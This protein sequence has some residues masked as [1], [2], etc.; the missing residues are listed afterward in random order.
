[1]DT[2]E[3]PFD[4]ATVESQVQPDGSVLP[5]A[6]QQ[7]PFAAPTG[8]ATPAPPE[9]YAHL[10][11]DLRVPW[12]WTDIVISFFFAIGCLLLAAQ[13]LGVFAA[14]WG[15]VQPVEGAALATRLAVLGV[16]HTIVTF[17]LVMLYLGLL[18]RIRYKR[19]FW[20]TIGFRVFRV[21]ELSPGWSIAALV[22]LGMALS[23]MV[24]SLSGLI[25]VEEPIPMQRM[26]EARE[27][28]LLFLLAAVVVAPL[29]EETLFRGWLYPVVARTFGVAGG[30]VITGALF[31]LMHGAQLGGHWQLVGLLTLVGVLLTWVRA[32]TGSVLSSY[33]LHLGYNAL[34]A[35]GFIVGTSGLR[36]LPTP[37]Q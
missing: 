16:L 8:L 5:A 32:R 15:A 19:P 21:G 7:S 3:K 17:G 27:S 14:A 28:A 26:F 24:A 13:V 35:I 20:E 22:F 25:R 11:Q 37:G 30:V 29:V 36:N 34:I 9:P 6:G 12:T 2:P 23:V 18:V 31:G 4:S 33:F 1:M 10:P